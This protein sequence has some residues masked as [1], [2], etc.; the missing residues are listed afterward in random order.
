M[1]MKFED[2]QSSLTNDQP[3]T[4]IPCLAALWYAGKGDWEKAHNIAQDIP[5]RDGI[6]PATSL[7]QA[8]A[9]IVR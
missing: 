3:P 7:H 6:R 9:A 2:F 1:N 4:G 5:T 8:P